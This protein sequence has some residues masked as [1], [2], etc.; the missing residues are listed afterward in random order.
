MGLFWLVCASLPLQCPL[1]ASKGKN[2]LNGEQL[3]DIW[4]FQ[5]KIRWW[6]ARIL[7]PYSRPLYPFTFSNP[8]CK[9][10]GIQDSNRLNGIVLKRIARHKTEKEKEYLNNINYQCNGNSQ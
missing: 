2:S 9:Y 5:L 1:S 6:R 4:L 8:I 10:E 7:L 3:G